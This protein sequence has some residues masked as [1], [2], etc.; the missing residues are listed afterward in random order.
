M[1]AWQV[2]A[3]IYAFAHFAHQRFYNLEAMQ[4]DQLS[5][6]NEITLLLDNQTQKDNSIRAIAER[7]S[8]M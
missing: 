1:Y 8:C 2:N 4:P 5:V 3:S 7:E 6:T